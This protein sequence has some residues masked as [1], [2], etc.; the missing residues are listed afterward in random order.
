ME[1]LPEF[2][3]S[4]EGGGKRELILASAFEVFY[5]KGFYQA[6]IEEIAQKAGIGKGTVYLYFSSKEHLLRELLKELVSYYHAVL[7]QRMATDTTPRERLYS[8]FR[9]HA[10]IV[11]KHQKV[12]MLQQWDFGVIDEELRN[13]LFQQR[14]TFLNELEELV[15]EGIQAGQFRPVNA[16]LAALILDSM[17]GAIVLEEETITGQGLQPFLDILERGILAQSDLTETMIQPDP[18]QE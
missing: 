11:R 4:S 1:E 5:Q 17:L 2:H 15:E 12:K 18:F 7:R 6:K 9:T 10:A 14:E 8:V 13:W 3:W 16:R